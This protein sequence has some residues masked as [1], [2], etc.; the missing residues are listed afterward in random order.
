MVQL[1]DKMLIRIRVLTTAFIYLVLSSQPTQ[2]DVF[3]NYFGWML[4]FLSKR[5]SDKIICSDRVGQKF[6]ELS[7]F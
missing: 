5:N 1:Y 4:N 2:F 3:R 6:T 7:R